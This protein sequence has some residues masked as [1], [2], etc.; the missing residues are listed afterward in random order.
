MKAAGGHMEF[1]VASVR[2][3]SAE[4]SGTTVHMNVPLGPMDAYVLTGGLLS[5]TDFPLLQYMVFAYKLTGMQVQA[6]IKQL[7]KWATANHY[8]VQARAAI[9]NP[10]KDQF[11]LMMQALLEDRFKLKVHYERKEMPVYALV[12]DK[13]GKL[14]PQFRE[15]KDDGAPCTSADTVENG[16]AVTTTGGY[17][18]QCGVVT[19]WQG[20][21]PGTFRLGARAILPSMM[22]NILWSFYA[23]DKPMAD[24]TGL[25]PVDFLIEFSPQNLTSTNEQDHPAGPTFQ[26]ALKEQLG[27]KVEEQSGVVDSIVIDHVEE[28]SEN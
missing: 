5:A 17:P 3:D 12:V 4:Q 19:F 6:A 25:G 24:K 2:P 21:Q 18:V 22:A 16:N 10:T 9:A 11:R 13:P 15:H 14:G 8:D 28:P 1:D 27:L 23:T 26:E 20:K 7:P